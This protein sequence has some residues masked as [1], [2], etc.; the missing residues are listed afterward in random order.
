MALLTIRTVSFDTHATS[1]AKLTYLVI[2]STD[3][4]YHLGTHRHVGKSLPY[5]EDTNIP[6]VVR[7]PGVQK[8]VVSKIPSTV[9]DFAPTFLEIAGLPK[10]EFPPFLDGTSML[11]GWKEPHSSEIGRQKEAINIEF[12]GSAYSEIPTWQGGDYGQYFPGVYLNNTYKTM[13]IVSEDSAWVYSKWCTND[14]ELYNSLV[15]ILGIYTGDGVH[16]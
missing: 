2:Y 8:G 12:W 5:L 9:T 15:T 7:G 13:R 6:L 3:Q 1:N 4:G 10:E 11:N 16:S 14:T